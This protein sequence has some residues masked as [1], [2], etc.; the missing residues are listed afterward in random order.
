MDHRVV[1]P[2]V[3]RHSSLFVVESFAVVDAAVISRIFAVHLSPLDGTC[4]TI[5]MFP[6]TQLFY[7]SMPAGFV[8][9]SL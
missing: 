4:N 1:K 7:E 5:R 3:K 2:A 9:I 6:M 8:F